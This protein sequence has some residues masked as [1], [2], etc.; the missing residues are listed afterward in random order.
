MLELSMQ[1][2][3]NYSRMRIAILTLPLHTNYGGILQAWALQTVLERLGHKVVILGIKNSSH[4]LVEWPFVWLKRCILKVLDKYDNKIFIEII[5]RKKYN[6]EYG[7][8]ITFIKRRIKTLKINS[9][10]QIPYKQFDAIIVGSDQIW[11][12]D[13]LRYLWH[14][15]NIGKAFL[16]HISSHEL[17]KISYAASLGKD[18]WPFTPMDTDI[19]KKALNDFSALSVRELSAVHLFQRY[20]NIPVRLMA[21]P[22]LLL[23]AKDYE[24]LCNTKFDYSKKQITSYILDPNE[25]TD[26]IIKS[27]TMSKRISH[28][29][30][31][32]RSITGLSTSIENWIKGIAESQLVITDSFHGCVFS[33]IFH[34]PLIFIGN[35]N[36]GNTRFDSLI[37]LFGLHSNYVESPE[38]LDLSSDYRLPSNIGNTINRLRQESYRFL[39]D[40]ITIKHEFD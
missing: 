7:S 13:Y 34:R 40:A 26:H 3:N 15:D 25:D 4:Y 11:R 5:N 2:G 20:C 8:I 6:R 17:R 12:P 37:E 16:N 18:V 31:N 35:K 19:I 39:H 28:S 10:Q 27:I 22:T 33:I 9:L 30:L 29:E 38:R 36:R 21:D 24:I 32:K 1:D 23:E 14:C